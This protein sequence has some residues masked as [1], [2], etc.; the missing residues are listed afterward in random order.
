MPDWATRVSLG[1]RGDPGLQ[2]G[3]SSGD[4]PGFES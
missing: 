3:G 1:L 2:P 4:L